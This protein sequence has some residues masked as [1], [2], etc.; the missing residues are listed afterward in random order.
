M[1]G[2]PVTNPMGWEHVELASLVDAED[3]INYGVVQPG[4]ACSSSM[5]KPVIR[6]GDFVT[7]ELHLSRVKFIDPDIEEKH[8]RSRLTGTEILVSCVGSIG[9]ICKVPEAAAGFNIA[10]AVAKIPLRSNISRNFMVY[11]LRCESVQH[12]FQKETRTVSQPTL[13][14]SHIKAAPIIQPPLDLQRR[15][16]DIVESVEQQ[17]N[18]MRAHLA[19]LDALFASL[20]SR[21][22]NGEL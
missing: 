16:A 22:F 10:R 8:K 4:D 20:Q 2:D 5:G 13:N 17:K 1:F 6:V 15:F 18:R 7:G 3:K 12:Y 21:A 19:E 14:I 9:T 11:C